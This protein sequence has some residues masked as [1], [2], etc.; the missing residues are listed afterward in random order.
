MQEV[1]FKLLPFLLPI[2]I[3]YIFV[4]GI[5][6]SSKKQ[7]NIFFK[8]IEEKILYFKSKKFFSDED[9]DRAKE[10]LKKE[11]LEL[12]DS[13]EASNLKETLAIRNWIL[14]QIISL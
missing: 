7:D 3:F 13:L 12:H 4:K 14:R 9:K 10:N 8:P 6:F 1:F 11:L 5:S 2:I